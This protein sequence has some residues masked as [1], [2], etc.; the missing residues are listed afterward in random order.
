MASGEGA[1][2]WLTGTESTKDTAPVRVE[3][4]TNLGDES[5][6]EFGM[7]VV[8]SEIETELGSIDGG[9]VTRSTGWGSALG[10]GSST[11][12]LSMTS[13]EFDRFRFWL[14]E[15]E[16]AD[17]SIDA[18]NLSAFKERLMLA[19]R[20]RIVYSAVPFSSDANNID[21]V[22]LGCELGGAETVGAGS[23]DV[24]TGLSAV[25][26]RW[27]ICTSAP[28]YASPVF[29]ADRRVLVKLLV[30]VCREGG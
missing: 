21:C 10:S 24:T 11:C 6:C 17:G 1:G 7:C 3:K 27:C 12:D 20:P 23:V 29:R 19:A 9:S 22:E 13:V 15:S 2:F 26:S 30:G 28:L 8:S 5:S 14:S 25:V 18:A 16:E 4:G